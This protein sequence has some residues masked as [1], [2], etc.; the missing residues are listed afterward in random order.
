MPRTLASTN[1]CGT[2]RARVLSTG[3]PNTSLRFSF[4]VMPKPKDTTQENKECAKMRSQETTIFA[5]NS[6][7]SSSTQEGFTHGDR[8]RVIGGIYKHRKGRFLSFAGK[9]MSNL[10]LFAKGRKKSCCVR[11]RSYNVSM[12]E[13]P[14]EAV[15]SRH[16]IADNMI[17]ES[18]EHEKEDATASRRFYDGDMAKMLKE[19]RGFVQMIGLASL[20][21]LKDIIDEE[22]RRRVLENEPSG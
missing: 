1:Q 4:S 2:Q 3:S 20:F 19:L 11:I 8:V 12:A 18:E 6:A 16:P 9:E 21:A 15:E 13:P 17:S 5:V 22:I 14:I 10:E 7:D